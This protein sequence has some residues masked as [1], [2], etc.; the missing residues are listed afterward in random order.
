[1]EIY[2]SNSNCLKNFSTRW[3]LNLQSRNS[4]SVSLLTTLQNPLL[5]ILFTKNSSDNDSNNEKK[6]DDISS[7]LVKSDNENKNDDFEIFTQNSTNIIE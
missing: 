1:M 2:R 3:E 6:R 5:Y 4:C 7:Y